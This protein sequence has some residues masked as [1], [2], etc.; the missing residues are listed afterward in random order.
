[1]WLFYQK[2]RLRVPVHPRADLF[3]QSLPSAVVLRWRCRVIQLNYS[4]NFPR[5][6]NLYFHRLAYQFLLVR[7]R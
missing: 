3:L 2:H 5:F 6:Q 7:C 4:Q 1:M